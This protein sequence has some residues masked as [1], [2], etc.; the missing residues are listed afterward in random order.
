MIHQLKTRTSWSNHLSEPCINPIQSH[1]PPV[2]FQHIKTTSLSNTQHPTNQ[3]K[4]GA[5]LPCFLQDAFS[6][7]CINDSDPQVIM[8]Q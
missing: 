7:H 1:L 2:S 8:F 3:R 5:T 6:L 4:V